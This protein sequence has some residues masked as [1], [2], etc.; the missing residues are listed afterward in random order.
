MEISSI[1]GMS[2]EGFH[3][4]SYTRWGNKHNPAVVCVHGLTRNARDFDWLAEALS[5]SYDVVCPDMVGR[6]LSDHFKVPI[7]YNIP[8]YMSDCNAL[9]ARL[10]V[11]HV[12]WIGT[13]MGGLIGMSIASMTGSPIRRL[14]I[15][16]VGPFIPSSALEYIHAYC[17]KDPVFKQFEEAYAFFKKQYAGFVSKDMPDY[18]A[19]ITKHSIKTMPDGSFKIN[20]DPHVSAELPGAL[21]QDIDLWAFW[22]KITCPILVLR[23]KK[24]EVF[25]ADVLTEMKRRRPDIE[26][27]EFDNIG[28][29][30]SLAEADQIERIQAWLA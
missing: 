15:N 13:S 7:H 8:Q 11:P 5:H 10:D 21:S 25:P 22:D 23:G 20:R 3:K 26:I 1:L 6:G 16:D 17:Q 14:V 12:D 4:V 2:P 27:A 24:S 29:A 28:H 19:H 9:I 30:P 18:W